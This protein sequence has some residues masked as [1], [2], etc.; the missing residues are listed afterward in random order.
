MTKKLLRRKER[1][2]LSYEQFFELSFGGPSFPPEFA[3]PTSAF[4]SEADR[5]EAWR[6]CGAEI[7][8]EWH[9]SHPDW[10]HTPLWGQRQYDQ[11]QNLGRAVAIV[12]RQA[13]QAFDEVHD[14]YL[15]CP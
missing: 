10:E 8:E 12:G 7:I 15:P 9:G 3:Y 14:R 2:D 11:P 6:E 4:D 1:R 5:E 13:E